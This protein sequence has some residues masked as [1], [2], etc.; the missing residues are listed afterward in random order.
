VPAPAENDYS[1]KTGSGRR[2]AFITISPQRIG[3]ERD[4]RNNNK[5]EGEQ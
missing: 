3:R 1:A 4:H 5:S 2:S